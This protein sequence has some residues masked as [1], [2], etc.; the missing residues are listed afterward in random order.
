MGL[1]LSK[2]FIEIHHGRIKVKSDEGKGTTFYIYLPLGNQHL[3][4]EEMVAEETIP[5]HLLNY[6]VST[7]KLVTSPGD[8]E[9]KMN[10]AE[11]PLILL[12]EDMADVRDF[13]RFSLGNKYQIVEAANGK[14]ALKWP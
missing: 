7:P 10:Q 14:S 13:I 1:S 4:P 2:E 11:K 5:K 9:N 6:H 12:V 8:I 3:R